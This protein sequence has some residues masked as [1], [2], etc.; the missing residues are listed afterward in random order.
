MPVLAEVNQKALEGLTGTV[1]LKSLYTQ[2]DNG[3]FRLDVESVNGVALEDVLGLKSS[4]SKTLDRA[5]GAEKKL[6]EFESRYEGIEPDKARDAIAKL[7]EFANGK[8]DDKSK[9]QIDAAVNQFKE[10]SA[11]EAEILRKEIEKQKADVDKWKTA[12][13]NKSKATEI[14][15]AIAKVGAN[16]NLSYYLDTVTKPE[17]QENG[18][19]KLMIRDKQ[20]NVKLTN[21]SGSVEPMTVE[22]HVAELKGIDSFAAFFPGTGAT[23]TGA[24]GA[25]T[26][27]VRAGQH[28]ISRENAT[29]PQL[30]R[31]AKEAAAK[32]GTTLQIAET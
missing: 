4:L 32:A 13:V 2:Q 1:E 8:F 21:K 25:H 30:Y 15:A 29:N 31:A 17:L 14:N 22:E 28:I 12:A 11:Q 26:P 5:K 27:V 10:K 16:P 6:K 23:G 18:D 20:G 3:M 19:I 9:A 24:T 7:E